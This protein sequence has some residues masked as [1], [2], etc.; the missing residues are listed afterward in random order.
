MMYLPN[1]C[2]MLSMILFIFKIQLLLSAEYSDPFVAWSVC[3]PYGTGC[4]GKKINF[5]INHQHDA[6]QSSRFNDAFLLL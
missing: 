4:N 3:Y 5:I 1:Y 6:L 2:F